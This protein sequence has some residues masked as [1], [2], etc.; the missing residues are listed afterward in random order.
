MVE[1]EVEQMD[2][3]EERKPVVELDWRWIRPRRGNLLVVE[4]EVE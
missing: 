1:L 3:A 4:L 2:S